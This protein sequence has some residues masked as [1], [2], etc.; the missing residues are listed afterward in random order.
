MKNYTDI[1]HHFLARDYQ[2]LR[3]NPASDQVPWA[4]PVNQ[5]IFISVKGAQRRI[6]LILLSLEE[7]SLQPEV[8]L[9]VNDEHGR[10]SVA[11]SFQEFFD[12]L[13]TSEGKEFS[14]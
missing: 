2:V 4:P 1:C 3:G 7:E 6:K 8:L 10:N 12:L 13:S 9:E 14:A 11:V 5:E